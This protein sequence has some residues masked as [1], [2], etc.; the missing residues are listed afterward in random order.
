MTLQEKK[1]ILCELRTELARYLGLIVTSKELLDKVMY[2][3][4]AMSKQNDILIIRATPI[5]VRSEFIQTFH[6]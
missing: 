5:I 6:I 2:S 4:M 3:Y 1:I